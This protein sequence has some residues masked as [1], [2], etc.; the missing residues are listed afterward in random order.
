MSE[1]AAVETNVDVNLELTTQPEPQPAT[2][3]KPASRPIVAICAHIKD[4]GLR[5]GTPAVTGRNFC[6]YHCRV[7]HPGARM[8]T[9]QYRAPLPDSVTSLQVAL[10]HTL[11]ALGTGDLEPKKANSMMF[12]INLATNLLRLAKPLTE[13]EQQQVVTE[14]PEP[15]QQVLASTDEPAAEVPPDR[16]QAMQVLEKEISKLRSYVLPPDRLRLCEHDVASLKGTADPRY[17]KA[18]ELISHHDYGVKRL[19]EMGVM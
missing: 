3:P 5:C 6:Y 13:T 8:A 4:D 9:R 17:Y 16:V 7:H 10:A 14:I 1:A 11:Q 12:G 2:E 15:M 18:C 19:R